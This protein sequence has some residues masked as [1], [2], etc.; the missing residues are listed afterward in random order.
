M[1]TWISLTVVLWSASASAD[2]AFTA[3]PLGGA[4][5]AAVAGAVTAT[6]NLAAPSDRLGAF[7]EV[8]SIG[9]TGPIAIGGPPRPRDSFSSNEIDRVM[10]ASKAAIKRC[11]QTELE[12]NKDLSGKVVV[13]FTIGANG[14]VA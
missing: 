6:D 13:A 3:A 8:T 9:P 7:R 2:V 12:K 1:R 11:Y 4:L 5:E 14:S 10:Y